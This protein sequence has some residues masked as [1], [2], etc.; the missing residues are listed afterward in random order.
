MVTTREV[1]VDD[2]TTF[3]HMVTVLLPE[4][5]FEMQAELDTRIVA[6]SWP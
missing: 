6:T 4:F 3:T 2:A 5:E 1:S